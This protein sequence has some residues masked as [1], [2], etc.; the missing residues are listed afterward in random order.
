MDQP[1]KYIRTDDSGL[2]E[3]IIE[4]VSGKVVVV[5]QHATDLLKLPG[6]KIIGQNIFQLIE[7]DKEKL[8]PG[9]ITIKK[10]LCSLSLEEIEQEDETLIKLK[11]QPISGDP[12]EKELDHYSQ[13]AEQIVHQFRSPLT[14]VFGFV[15]ILEESE[16]S[17]SKLKILEKIRSGMQASFNLLDRIEKF[18][19]PVSANIS[20]FDISI[21]LQQF[22]QSIPE[23]YKDMI[24]IKQSDAG[25]ITSDFYLLKTILEE[26]TKNAL[27]EIRNME[28]QK[29]E[30]RF[31]RKGNI[32]IENH[33][34]SG[35]LPD[36]DKIFMPF[37]TTSAGKTGLG[38][39]IC[40][41]YCKYMN[42]VIK[43]ALSEN[44]DSIKFQ[45]RNILI[46]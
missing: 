19:Q 39:P 15:E 28:D 45:I 23:N 2:A 21:L 9:L 4:K 38:L 8:K 3:I 14:G 43:A 22:L 29:V 27:H 1:G 13:I 41:K 18:A 31:S 5:N 40:K 6:K 36:I 17:A 16:T 30:I 12:E 35:H 26:L 32:E 24:R 20:T 10:T 34:T 44:R 33:L 46:S 37:Y 25:M 11:L 42:L 7:R